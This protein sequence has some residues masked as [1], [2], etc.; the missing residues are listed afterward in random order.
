VPA[1]SA[2]NEAYLEGQQLLRRLAAWERDVSQIDA[3]DTQCK[4]EALAKIEAARRLLAEA[5]SRLSQLV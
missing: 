2:E 4:T 3:S 5:L 1:V